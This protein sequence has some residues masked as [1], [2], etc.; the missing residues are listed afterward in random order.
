MELARLVSSS[1]SSS[2]KHRRA[3]SGP[4]SNRGP[5][6]EKKMLPRYPGWFSATFL[7][8]TFFRS[9]P[10][11]VGNGDLVGFWPVLGLGHL[12][13]F[14]A[15]AENRKTQFPGARG[16]E[17]GQ[18]NY[19][20]IRDGCP[21]LSYSLRFERSD[22]HGRENAKYKDFGPFWPRTAVGT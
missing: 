12:Q 21:Q 5:K 1:S 19:H 4:Q 9:D 20:A 10:H 15:R 3:L 6:I 16:P 2:N 7:G 13:R 8:T 14:R 22:P 18:K 11:A 17:T